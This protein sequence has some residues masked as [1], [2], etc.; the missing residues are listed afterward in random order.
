MWK[1]VLMI[2]R[3]SPH[4]HWLQNS[5]ELALVTLVTYLCIAR[6]ADHVLPQQIFWGQ[7]AFRIDLI[8]AFSQTDLL[9]LINV[10]DVQ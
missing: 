1:M 3:K 9:K 7:V 8:I 5:A 2:S 10:N 6:T 4:D